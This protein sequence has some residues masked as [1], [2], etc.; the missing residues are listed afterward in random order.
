MNMTK[1]RK[2]DLLRRLNKFRIKGE[3]GECYGWSGATSKTGH[4]RISFMGK[5]I[6]ANRG[7]WM[8]HFCKIPEFQYVRNT[9]GNLAC[10]N[11]DHLF[12][13]I[14]NTPKV[15]HPDRE[16]GRLH[17]ERLSV[18]LPSRLVWGLKK[19]SRKR[20]ITVTKYMCILIAK[21]LEIEKSYEIQPTE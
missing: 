17:R 2:D 6:G 15:R 13:S 16:T 7:A 9:C 14:N 19:I 3:P 12:T 8:A 4:P 5:C 1:K 20:N 11:P 21:A 10:T 18:D